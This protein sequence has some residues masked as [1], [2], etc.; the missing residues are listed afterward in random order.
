MRPEAPL[1][2]LAARGY[3]CRGLQQVDLFWSGCGASAFD[4]Y[5]DGLRIATVS[6]TGYTDRLERGGAGSYR[7]TVC[8]IATGT[9][10]NETLVTFA[11]T[12]SEAERGPVC[13]RVRSAVAG[14]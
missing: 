14:R 2:G 4:V 6:T 8:E 13:T 1:P 12:S 7:Y 11:A 9:H 5:R 10:S 3:R